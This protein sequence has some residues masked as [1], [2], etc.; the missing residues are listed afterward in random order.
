MQ[1]SSQ[2]ESHRARRTA[3]ARQE[4]CR[5]RP[6]VRPYDTLVGE[7]IKESGEIDEQLFVPALGI[8]S[9][10]RTH[11][12]VSLRGL[13][14]WLLLEANTEGAGGR[15]PGRAQ[16]ELARVARVT[17]VESI[18]RYDTKKYVFVVLRAGPVCGDLEGRRVPEIQKIS[19]VDDD[20]SV[21]E[22]LKSFLKSV[23]F[24][25]EAFASAEEFLNSGHLPGAACLILDVRMPRRRGRARSKVGRSNSCRNR[26][27]TRPCSM[28]STRPSACRVRHGLDEAVSPEP[29]HERPAGQAEPPRSLRLVPTGRCQGARDHVALER[30]D[31]LVQRGRRSRSGGGRG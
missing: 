26:S 14:A 17:T 2:P 18:P 10:E 21:R 15:G 27:A 19:I 13:R 20:E 12:E 1:P 11:T 6:F 23:G 8:P 24:E 25:A 22:A 30:L 31:L 9:Q 7:W 3:V 4:S 29:V 28:P 16:P 5:P